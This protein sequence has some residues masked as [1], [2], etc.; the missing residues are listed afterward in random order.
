MSTAAATAEEIK[1]LILDKAV[2]RFIQYGFGKTTM[3]EIAK[4]CGMSAGNLYRYFESKFDIGV[5]VAQLYICKAEQILRD[6]L[7]RP[8]LSPSQRLEAFVLEKL[9]FMHSQIIEQPNVQ[10]LV[11]YILD[12]RWDLVERHRDVQNSLMAE[13]LSEGNRTGEFNVSDVVHTANAIYALT[14][15]FR[16]PHFIKNVTLEGLEQE[17]KA[18]VDLMIR[19]IKG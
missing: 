8:G 9:R 12:D 5:G 19:G 2:D 7:K 4:D 18:G 11:D 14:T 17:A 16:L 10:D 3:V 15:K 1:S 6:V 13:I